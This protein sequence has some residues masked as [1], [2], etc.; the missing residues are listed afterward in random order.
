MS[1]IRKEISC[2]RH[3]H[4]NKNSGDIQVKSDMPTATGNIVDLHDV[5]TVVATTIIYS[6][7]PRNK[8]HDGPI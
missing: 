5:E 4:M 1:V 8:D 6:I 2:A 7:P 3:N